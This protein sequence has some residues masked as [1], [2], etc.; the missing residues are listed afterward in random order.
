MPYLPIDPA[1]I[2]RSYDA[3]IRINSQSGKGGIAYLLETDYGTELPRRLQIDFAQRVQ[4][5]TDSTGLE[6]DAPKLLELFEHSYLHSSTNDIELLELE[7]ESRDGTTRTQV[8]IRIDG[9]ECSGCYD[10]IGPV[11]A[12]TELLAEHGYPIDILSLHQTSLTEGNSSEALTLIEYRT[13][14]G[15]RWAAGRDRS[16]LT[17]SVNAILRAARMEAATLASA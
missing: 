10:G 3:A 4:E 15:T 14:T 5:H 7:S 9:A 17:A 1:D 11:E 2:G 12:V 8:G 6:V 13:S 16:V